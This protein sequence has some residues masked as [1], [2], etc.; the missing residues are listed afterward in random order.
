MAPATGRGTGKRQ[1][2]A[3]DRR[4]G[5][6][7]LLMVAPNNSRR[8]KVR[9]LRSLSKCS[10]A[11]SDRFGCYIGQKSTGYRIAEVSPPVGQPARA[12]MLSALLDARALTAGERA[13]AARVTPQTASTH[14]AKL[15]EAGLV[16]W[17]R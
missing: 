3:R 12:T 14:L 1:A 8:I 10:S 5:G 13:H 6:H 15:T 4:R 9:P 2:R 17:G 16:L 11:P 7:K